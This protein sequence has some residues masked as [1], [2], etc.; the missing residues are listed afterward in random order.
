L[1]WWWLSYFSQVGAA[2][3]SSVGPSWWEASRASSGCSGSFWWALLSRLA[4]PKRA[5]SLWPERTVWSAYGNGTD[6]VL[7]VTDI[8]TQ[9]PSPMQHG[10]ALILGLFVV[11]VLGWVAVVS[12][13][14]PVMSAVA[15]V[16]ALAIAWR[17][18]PPPGAGVLR[19]VVAVFGGVMLGSAVIVA[20][21]G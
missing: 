11:Y 1:P 9:R 8:S 16:A 2:R 4:A 5:A 18:T 21:L 19:W 13:G 10:I 7:G 12:M 3:E 14:D 6:I 15:G 17:V 20:F